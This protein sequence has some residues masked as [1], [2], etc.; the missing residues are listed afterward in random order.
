MSNPYQKC[1]IGDK[2]H[3]GVV[4][5][6]EVRGLCDE[7]SANGLVDLSPQH[8]MQW[9]G[10]PINNRGDGTPIRSDVAVNLIKPLQSHHDIILRLAS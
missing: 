2:Y 8:A 10:L 4:A 3:I 5:S 9:E 7:G 6:V 1:P